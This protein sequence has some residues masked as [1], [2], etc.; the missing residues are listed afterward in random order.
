M[1]VAGIALLTG[2][3]FVLSSAGLT[4]TDSEPTESASLV[5]DGVTYRFSPTTCTVTDTDFL[6]AGAGTINGE[7]FWVSASADRV[8]LAVGPE[9][10]AER[11]ADD[12]LWLVSIREVRWQAINKTITA[13]ALLGDERLADSPQVRSQLSV[14]CAPS[15]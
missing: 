13:T 9:T 12:Q 1:L 2:F 11:P 5:V 7:T 8:N 14:S 6:A 15:V 10:E 4:G 3:A